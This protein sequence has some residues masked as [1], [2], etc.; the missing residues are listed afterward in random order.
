M[1]TETFT[2]QEENKN[3]SILQNRLNKTL[4]TGIENKYDQWSLMEL[5]IYISG[6]DIGV[7]YGGDYWYS[8]P[9]MIIRDKEKDSVCK[10]KGVLLIRVK[11]H[12]RV[13]KQWHRKKKNYGDYKWIRAI[14]S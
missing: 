9:N 12:S 4:D 3:S 1:L 8:L 14:W 11:E 6:L 5:D 10:D 7:E 2:G 13:K